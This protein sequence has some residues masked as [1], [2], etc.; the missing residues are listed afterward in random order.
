MN[1][2]TWNALSGGKAQRA[3]GGSAR[4]HVGMSLIPGS[5]GDFRDDGLDFVAGLV[6]AIVEV[7]GLNAIAEV[8]QMREQPDRPFRVCAASG[9]NDSRTPRR[10]ECPASPR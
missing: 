9:P 3:V 8:P 10:A 4:E 5:V 6:E 2:E 7:T 1:G